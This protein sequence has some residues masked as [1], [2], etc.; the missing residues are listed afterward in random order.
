[1]AYD[2]LQAIHLLAAAADNFNRRCLKELKADPARGRAMIEQSLA[3]CTALAPVIGYDAA[4]AIAKEAS[5]TGKTVREIARAR[6]VLP[7]DRLNQLL[8]PWS[9][10]EPG[11]S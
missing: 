5:R 7:A 8:D 4:A 11:A 3:M 9:M 2:L 10:T 6:N 1:M